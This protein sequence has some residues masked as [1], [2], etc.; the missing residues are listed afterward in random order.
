M[1]DY[2]FKPMSET[3][4]RMTYNSRNN[5]TVVIKCVVT[6]S[7]GASKEVTFWLRYSPY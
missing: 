2:E 4:N 3:S 5:Y 7:A 1:D 6:D